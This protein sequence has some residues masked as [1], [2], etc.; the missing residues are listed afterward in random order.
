[1]TV[2]E[3]LAFPLKR[4]LRIRDEAEIET[5][6]LEVLEAVGLEDAMDKLPADL[7]GGMRKRMGL[8]RTLIVRPEI[9]LYDE[10]TT[11][12]DTITSKEISNLIL[13]IKK[14]YQTSSIII[15]HDISC[16]RITSDRVAIMSEGHFLVEGTFDELEKSDDKFIQSFFK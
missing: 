11:G 10:P 9:M 12:L 4:V 6:S 3:N 2:R 16:A 14:K 7:S 5:R 1:M 13:E 8:A 15:T